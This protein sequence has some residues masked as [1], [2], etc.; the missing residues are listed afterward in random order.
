MRV[1][2]RFESWAAN[3][4]GGLSELLRRDMNPGLVGPQ[5]CLEAIA[6]HQLREVTERNAD[7]LQES[8]VRAARVSGNVCCISRETIVRA[9]AGAAL[10]RLSLAL[11]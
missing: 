10:L 2:S 6:R 11:S 9:A 3:R 1:D 7:M 8:A 4:P 5:R